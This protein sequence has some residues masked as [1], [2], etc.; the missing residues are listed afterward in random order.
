M[1]KIILKI[2]DGSPALSSPCVVWIGEAT[3]RYLA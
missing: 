1:M 2:A 3:D